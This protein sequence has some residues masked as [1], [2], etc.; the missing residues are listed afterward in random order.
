MTLAAPTATETVTPEDA[1]NRFD[2]LRSRASGGRG[3]RVVIERN[4]APV[5]ALVSARDLERLR[6]LEE[7]RAHAWRVLEEFSRH[8]DDVSD[9]GL[10]REINRAVAEA[11]AQL[12]AERQQQATPQP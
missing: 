4:G 6:Q 7:R 10:E 2:E 3:Q 11:R 12:R 5:A 8:F 1:R 9:E